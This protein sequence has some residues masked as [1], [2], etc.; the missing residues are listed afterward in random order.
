MNQP[1]LVKVLVAIP[2]VAVDTGLCLLAGFLMVEAFVG[3]A[4]T[5]PA[6]WWIAPVSAISALTFVAALIFVGSG[7]IQH[8]HHLREPERVLTC[9]LQGLGVNLLGLVLG[10]LLMFL[11]LLSGA[12]LAATH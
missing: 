10:V 8:L 5:F 11:F 3:G 1:R 9:S 7:A 4:M 6:L 12:V 2:L